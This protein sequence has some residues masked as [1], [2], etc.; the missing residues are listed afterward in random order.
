[1]NLDPTTGAVVLT[2]SEYRTMERAAK[3]FAQWV[4]T[5]CTASWSKSEW[6]Y[7]TRCALEY[8]HREGNPEEHVDP[9]GRKS[10]ARRDADDNWIE[11]EPT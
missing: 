2:P 4:D 3:R 8:G 9:K 1:M 11:V 5:R 6:P 7:V 10:Y